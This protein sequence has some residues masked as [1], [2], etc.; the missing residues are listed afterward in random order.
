MVS[1]PIF[2]ADQSSKFVEVFLFLQL[3][4]LIPVGFIF[5][6]Y[7]QFVK[8][9]KAFY[10]LLFSCIVSCLGLIYIV[11]NN[12]YQYSVF[13][14]TG[15]NS[16]YLLDS[17]GSSLFIKTYIQELETTYA[18][19]GFII[20]FSTTSGRT[21]GSLLVT[22]VLNLFG[23]EKMYLIMYGFIS[24]LFIGLTCSV[25]ILRRQLRVKAITKIKNN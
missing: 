11:D 7:I 17:M 22:I 10:G 16:A 2:L 6:Y 18:N 8:E 19:S 23:Y 14:F 5:K 9:K 21:I 24:C 13:F 12:V 25:L 3:L 4:S 20:S 15:V 1:A